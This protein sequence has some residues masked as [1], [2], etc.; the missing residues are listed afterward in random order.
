MHMVYVL[1]NSSPVFT[2]Q[3]LILQRQLLIERKCSFN[4]KIGNLGRKC[5]IASP[6]P[7]S[8]IL[9]SHGSLLFCFFFFFNFYYIFDYSHLT[10]FPGGSDG[11]EYAC[12]V[13]DLGS[14][15]GSGIYP[16]EGNVGPL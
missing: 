4:Q 15:P 12:N 16:G 9:F 8:N 7:A 13:R 11:K 14:I 3:K 10:D 1:Q 5:V 6:Q 2:A